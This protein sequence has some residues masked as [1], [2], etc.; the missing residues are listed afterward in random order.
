MHSRS[1][2][3]RPGC[4]DTVSEPP[5]RL[6]SRPTRLALS[7]APQPSPR[8]RARHR[9]FHF[10]AVGRGRVRPRRGGERGEVPAAATHPA[11]GRGQCPSRGREQNRGG[12]RSPRP[13][14]HSPPSP[15]ARHVPPRATSPAATPPPCARLQLTARGAAAPAT[16]GAP[17]SPVGETGQGRT[18]SRGSQGRRLRESWR[19]GG[20]EGGRGGRTGSGVSAR[21]PGGAEEPEDVGGGGG[22]KRGEGGAEAG[23]RPGEADRGGVGGPCRLRSGAGRGVPAPRRQADAD[24]AWKGS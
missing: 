14:R 5:V 21:G 11:L 3:C 8:S 12:E 20:R 13:A 18:E 4:G 10:P 23:R 2:G 9:T 17:G 7:P 19:L 24:S 6:A 16:V 1:R 15:S 22:R